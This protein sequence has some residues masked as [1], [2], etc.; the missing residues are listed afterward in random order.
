MLNNN[1]MV[2]L[3][4]TKQ[5]LKEQEKKVSRYLLDPV[6]VGRRMWD[7]TLLVMLLYTGTYSPY[8]T[9]FIAEGGNTFLLIIENLMD[10]L[11]GIDILV[12]FFTPFERHD[13]SYEYD[14]KKIAEFYVGGG[15]FFID[16]IAAFPFQLFEA[17]GNNLGGGDTHG[18]TTQTTK[19]LRLL[20]MQRLYRL[21]RL[22]RVLKLLKAA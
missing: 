15:S 13:G 5:K 21:L 6:S 20:R 16:V 8:R 14:H 1:G 7:F 11:F 22:V 3:M 2:A 18:S 12:N 9:A 19:Y 17:Q 4:Q 10:F